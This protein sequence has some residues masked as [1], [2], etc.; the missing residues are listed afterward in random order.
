MVKH[1]LF[2]LILLTSIF[3]NNLF[4]LANSMLSTT[5]IRPNIKVY[6]TELKVF[7]ALSVQHTTDAESILGKKVPNKPESFDAGRFKILFKKGREVRAIIIQTEEVVGHYAQVIPG[8]TNIGGHIQILNN[9]EEDYGPGKILN[10]E[11][12][13][14]FVEIIYEKFREPLSEEEACQ[15]N[16]IKD[17][18]LAIM[19]SGKDGIEEYHLGQIEKLNTE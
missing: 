17:Y 14:Y 5:V 6:L 13:K 10:T 11:E 4:C 9:P 7:Q 15:L 2:V 8:K 1:L 3:L 16:K 18:A 19:F 12:L